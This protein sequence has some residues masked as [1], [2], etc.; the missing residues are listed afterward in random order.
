MKDYVSVSKDMWSGRELHTFSRRELE[1]YQ[2]FPKD[3]TKI[4]TLLFLAAIPF[5]G[6][7]FIVIGYMYPRLF[8]THHLWNEEQ[9]VEFGQY[10]HKHK[11]S[12]YHNLLEHFD[13]QVERHTDGQTQEQLRIILDEIACSSHPTV[14]ELLQVKTQF[15]SFP[16][17]VDDVPTVYFRHLALVCNFSKRRAQLKQDGLILLHIDRAMMREGIENLTEYEMCKS[18]L[19]RGL[20]PYGI[21]REER[22][23]FLQMWTE[24]SQQLDE[25]NV[26]LL[27]H[28]PVFLT[29]NS[30]TNIQ[31]MKGKKYKWHRKRGGLKLRKILS[32]KVKKKDGDKV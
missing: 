24:L 27:L 19:K 18:C 8:F 3:I 6:N 10:F 21:T 28:C 29:Y 7:G 31:L 32:S 25:K 5:I 15:E 14:D 17:S 9:K 20:N 11:L 4:V 26:S 23:K 30:A 16:F 22:I 13:K 12:H 1:I 2:E